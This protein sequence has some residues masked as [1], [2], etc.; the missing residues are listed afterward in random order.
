MVG[1]GAPALLL[2]SQASAS[3]KTAGDGGKTCG[4]KP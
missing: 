1:D 3:D 4:A 2:A